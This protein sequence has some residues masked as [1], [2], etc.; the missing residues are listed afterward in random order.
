MRRLVM[1]P[2]AAPAGGRRTLLPS[3]RAAPGLRLVANMSRLPGAWLT[4]AA[5]EA[6]PICL[7]GEACGNAGNPDSK[8]RGGPPIERQSR[9]RR[10][11][12]SAARRSSSA[13]DIGRSGRRRPQ[14]S[15]D[16]R[17]SG[18]RAGRRFPHLRK[19]MRILKP[20]TAAPPGAPSPRIRRGTKGDGV[21]GAAKKQ[22]GGAL[23]ADPPTLA[24]RAT[25][26]LSPPERASAKA[27]AFG[28][29]GLFDK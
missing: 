22:G 9:S 28:E 3:T 19:E 13:C 5:V 25:A 7:A 16:I 20:T 23:P 6:C 8:A 18:W 29:G 21:P 26:G 1:E 24:A 12:E 15:P 2:D 14:M 4:D 10:S 11:P 17:R 27:E